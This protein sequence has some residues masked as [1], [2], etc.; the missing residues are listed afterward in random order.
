[1]P[2][3]KNVTPVRFFEKNIRKGISFNTNIIT[4]YSSEK[5][6]LF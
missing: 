4:S 3:V 1:M 5:L 6:M 2:I